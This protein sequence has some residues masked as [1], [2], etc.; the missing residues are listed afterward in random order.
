MTCRE[1]IED[2]RTQIVDLSA[3]GEAA[4]AKLSDDAWNRG[5]AKTWSPAQIFEHMVLANG[6]Y[7]ERLPKGIEKAPPGGDRPVQHTWFGSFIYKAAGP[8]SNAPPPKVMVPG[9]GPFGNETFERW[10]RQQDELLGLLDAA[11]DRDLGT[12]KLRNPFIRLFRMTLCDF[13][14]ILATH[15]ERHV[16]Q[17]EERVAGTR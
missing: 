9:P 7:L 13:F 8:A 14:A 12:I 2:C 16:S 15:T 6:P 11:Q 10:R 4:R 3:R 5:S 1:F 17:I